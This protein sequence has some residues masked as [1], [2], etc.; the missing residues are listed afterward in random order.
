MYPPPCRMVHNTHP[1]PWNKILFV[2]AQKTLQGTIFYQWNN[3]GHRWRGD[4]SRVAGERSEAT[5]NEL[6]PTRGGDLR[7]TT[8]FPW[9]RETCS[10]TFLCAARRAHAPE[11]LLGCF[12]SAGNCTTPSVAAVHGMGTMPL[13][14]IIQR[15]WCKMK[16][17]RCY[18][19]MDHGEGTCLPSIIVARWSKIKYF[20][21]WERVLKYK[22]E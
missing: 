7:W 9:P 13:I 2:G 18:N 8:R 11:S 19:S 21:S 20:M 6:K 1:G 17:A 4:C 16:H 22:Y 14:G 5:G 3:L 15:I 12:E 10:K